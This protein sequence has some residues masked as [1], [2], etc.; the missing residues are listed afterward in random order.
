VRRTAKPNATARF[1]ELVSGG[2]DAGTLFATAMKGKVGNEGRMTMKRMEPKR[3]G[4][5]V[6][7]VILIA[8]LHRDVLEHLLGAVAVVA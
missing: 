8:V 1:I 3:N 6:G 7:G 5:M 2:G 4:A